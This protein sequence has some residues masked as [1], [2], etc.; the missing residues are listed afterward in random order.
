[1]KYAARLLP[2]TERKQNVKTKKS[3]V[4]NDFVPVAF[5]VR[6][7]YG[8]GEVVEGEGFLNVLPDITPEGFD[9]RV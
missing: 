9:F 4:R 3:S 7:G 1:M 8:L 5:H 6:E 2:N